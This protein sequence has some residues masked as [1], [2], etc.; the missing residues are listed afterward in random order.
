VTGQ[1]IAVVVALGLNLACTVPAA[2]SGSAL[3]EAA[4]EAG[5]GEAAEFT[6]VPDE[7]VEQTELVART[8]EGVAR[9]AA[10]V[11]EL[12][13]AAEVS[14]DVSSASGEG[15]P[16]SAA[17]ALPPDANEES[18]DFPESRIER[19]G[20][21]APTL[22]PCDDPSCLD[23]RAQVPGSSDDAAL[24]ESP[25]HGDLH[26]GPM[27]RHDAVNWTIAGL[28]SNSQPINVLSKLTWSGLRTDGAE[29]SGHLYLP[30]RLVTV[31][32]V[33]YGWIQAG[34]NEDSDFDGANQTLAFSRS[35]NGSG[36]T[37][38]DSSLALGYDLPL[39]PLDL[40]LTPLVGLSYLE[41]DL[42]IKNGFQ[43]LSTDPNLPLGPFPGLN[44]EYDAIWLGGWAGLQ[45]S[46]RPHPRLRISGEF[47]LYPYVHYVAD[48]NWNLRTDLQHPISY[49]DRTSG[50]GA[51]FALNVAWK[52][53]RHWDLDF[54][55]RWLNFKSEAGTDTTFFSPLTGGGSGATPFNGG[56]WRSSQILF[57]ATLRLGEL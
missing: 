29:I 10:P 46:L 32:R 51:E 41:Q 39:G 35:N 30:Y 57:G 48:G 26:F 12:P 19:R 4:A 34:S 5:A 27:F 28:N 53:T 9:A 33:S 42:V 52:M 8:A 24:A 14:S 49:T 20:D 55:A 13:A 22:P 45:M 37:T 16:G 40:H 54:R 1:R 50:R 31:A 18:R 11:E 56:H 3:E 2:P 25:I 7:S 15:K 21:A 43:S 44:S 47:K 36:G 17:A 23:Q 6:A 38:L